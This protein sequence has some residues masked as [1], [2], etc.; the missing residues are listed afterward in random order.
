MQKDQITNNS[1]KTDREKARDQYF[2]TE[3]NQNQKLNEILLQISPVIK[4]EIPVELVYNR[5]FRRDVL[6]SY[7]KDN[8]PE[9][10]KNA[11]INYNMFAEIAGHFPTSHFDNSLSWISFYI[12]DKNNF[13]DVFNDS[14]IFEF[15]KKY[16][17][18]SGTVEGRLTYRC[19]LA[20][21][22]DD[23][24]NGR[25]NAFF[26]A[27][28]QSEPTT[29]KNRLTTSYGS[30]IL[31]NWYLWKLM[32]SNYDQ[33]INNNFSIEILFKTSMLLKKDDAYQGKND[34]DPSTCT[35]SND[36]YNALLEIVKFAEEIK[37][38]NHF[39]ITQRFNSLS[40]IFL[41]YKTY[42][43]KMFEAIK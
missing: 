18:G 41:T 31:Q 4:M 7:E 35:I 39:Y 16:E 24:K 42:G 34:W 17:N 30:P 13:F 2:Q 6:S 36:D 25:C 21:H 26:E 5:H 10:L 22:L 3:K 27:C 33:V 8:F 40:E 37:A 11:I 14:F 38:A 32:D 15:H 43:K 19:F 12:L 28:K 1:P 29:L 20:N 23:I 9:N